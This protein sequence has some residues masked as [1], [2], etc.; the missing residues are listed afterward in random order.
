MERD[1]KE[2][3]GE[4][5]GAEWIVDRLRGGRELLP[6]GRLQRIDDGMGRNGGE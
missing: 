6:I 4:G 2:R 5:K 1:R 3:G